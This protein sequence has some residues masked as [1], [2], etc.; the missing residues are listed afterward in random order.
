[1]QQEWIFTWEEYILLRTTILEWIRVQI[2]IM[3]KT[4]DIEDAETMREVETLQHELER[5]KTE[6]IPPKEV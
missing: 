6:D 5:F 4:K 3:R 1:M 2:I